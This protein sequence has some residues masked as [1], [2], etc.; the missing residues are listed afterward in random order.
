MNELRGTVRYIMQPKYNTMSYIR[1]QGQMNLRILEN[2]L[3]PESTSTNNMSPLG[4][5]YANSRTCLWVVQVR[6]LI[7]SYGSC[8]FQQLRLELTS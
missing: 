5:M 8:Q 2:L 4:Q 6:L 1:K 3:R 7:L